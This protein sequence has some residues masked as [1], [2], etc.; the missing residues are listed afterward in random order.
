M[1]DNKQEGDEVLEVA[2]VLAQITAAMEIAMAGIIAELHGENAIDG[3][4][5]AAT[6]Q[7]YRMGLPAVDSMIS[8]I[9]H[10]ALAFIQASEAPRGAHLRPVDN[11]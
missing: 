10:R 4:R 11:D 9:G 2:T 3:R 6:L 1:N 7:A 8:D 5:F